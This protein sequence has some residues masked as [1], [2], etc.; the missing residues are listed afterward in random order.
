[1]KRDERGYAVGI[2]GAG[3]VGEIL[4]EVLEERG[5]PVRAL[6]IM[7][8]SARR[9]VFG[10]RERD[11]IAASPEAFEGLD[12]A[13]FAGTEGESGASRLYGWPAA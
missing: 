8:T 5:F 13:L 2:V 3:M 12:I 11:V 4:V 6:R 10:G 7:A 1:M 9:Q